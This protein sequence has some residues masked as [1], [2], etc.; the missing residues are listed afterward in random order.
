MPRFFHHLR[1]DVTRLLDQDGSV[2]ADL[3]AAIADARRQAR[4]LLGQELREDGVLDLT[5]SI[6]VTR[7]TGEVLHRLP[8]VDVVTI[9]GARKE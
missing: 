1:F 5:R 4:D 9:I 3:D 2:F 6:E 7:E 8:L